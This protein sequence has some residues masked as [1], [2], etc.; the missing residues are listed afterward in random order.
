[1]NESI[2]QWVLMHEP[3]YLQAA[4]G[5]GNLKKIGAEITT[6]KGRVD[7]IYETDRNEVLVIELETEI[8]SESKYQHCID[9]LLRYTQLE[10]KFNGKKVKVILLYANEGTATKY[11]TILAENAAAHNFLIRPYSLMEIKRLF[12]ATMNRLNRT[13][14]LTLS[15]SVALGV[16]SL[17]W[18][19]KFMVPFLNANSTGIRWNDLKAFFNSNTNFYVLKRLA[20]DFELISKRKIKRENCICL[21]EYGERFRDA[22]IPSGVLDDIIVK[23]HSMSLN[24]NNDSDYLLDILC[25]EQKRVLLDI[26][27]NG[28]FTKLKTNIFYF[29]RFVHLT[30]G[31]WMPKISTKLS[32]SQKLY[33]NNILNS[34]YSPRTLKELLQQLCNY[35]EDLELVERIP[36]KRCHYDKIILT[37]LGSRVIGYFELYLHLKREKLQIPLQIS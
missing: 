29:L 1:M 17:K 11:K 22:I 24:E 14:G 10:N 28:N 8:G 19:N 36:N 23:D 3:E 21:T 34:S 33:I 30:E 9:Q 20:E 16:S 18:L 15:K 32:S 31:E 2:V 35:C 37:S 13:S 7:F 6:L 27:L 25:L 4:L 5:F 26:L 12:Y